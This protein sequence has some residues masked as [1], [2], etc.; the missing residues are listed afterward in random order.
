VER[1]RE[2]LHQLAIDVF[3]GISRKLEFELTGLKGTHRICF[4][5]CVPLRDA[6]KQII[7]QLAVIRDITEERAQELKLQDLTGKL[8]SLAAHLE[9][10]REEE[11][12]EIAREIH[13]ELGQQLTAIKMDM[14]WVAKKGEIRD[15][16]VVKRLEDSMIL[17]D[18]MVNTVR[19]IAMDLRPSILDDLGLQ[20]ALKWQAHDFQK[21]SGINCRFT[22]N[23]KSEKVDP[24]VAIT[25]FRIY[26]E[27]L[28]NIRRHARASDV[29]AELKILKKELSLFIRDNGIG[30][31]KQEVERK[32][33]LG[34]VGM[35]ERILKLG[36]SLQVQS[37]PGKGTVVRVVV[38]LAAPI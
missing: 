10:V 19:R 35:E 31:D 15:P 34:I 29:A 28:T 7:A 32:K 11:R 17:L 30:F 5:H 4:I 16:S 6:H 25:L 13:D 8:R 3:N 14:A 9:D 37:E 18:I 2:D 27:S 12:A 23:N 20:E 33:T 26:Q 22:T 21:R 38:P 1:Y 24:A 36:G